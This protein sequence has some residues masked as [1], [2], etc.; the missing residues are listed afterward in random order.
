MSYPFHELDV[1]GAGVMPAQTCVAIV[2]LPEVEDIGGIRVLTASEF[3]DPV[4]LVLCLP[5]GEVQDI[6]ALLV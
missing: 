4:F 1:L 6:L 3:Q 2:T 5:H